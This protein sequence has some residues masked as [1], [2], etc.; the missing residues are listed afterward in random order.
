M[1]R[2]G[3]YASEIVI[4]G[5]EHPYARR[6]EAFFEKLPE[7]VSD[8]G[9]S[10][11]SGNADHRDRVN[12]DI[13]ERRAEPAERSARIADLRP[14]NGRFRKGPLAQNRGRAPRKCIGDECRTV[15]LRSRNG[16][17]EVAGLDGP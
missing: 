6:A 17:E 13:P 1:L 3:A 8:G 12:G 9:F 16:R 10:I 11:C 4:D 2:R 7:Q 15:Y 5:A 14:G